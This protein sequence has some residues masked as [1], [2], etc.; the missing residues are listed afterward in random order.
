VVVA[1]AQPRR[2]RRIAGHTSHG[3]RRDLSGR[4]ARLPAA[5]IAQLGV[6]DALSELYDDLRGSQTARMSANQGLMDAERHD[7]FRRVGTPAVRF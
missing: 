6:P 5:F 1:R 7:P 3:E 4:T 2:R